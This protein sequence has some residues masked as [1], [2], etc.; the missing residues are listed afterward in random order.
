M[1][2][3]VNTDVSALP[4]THWIAVYV[5]QRKGEVFDSYGRPPPFRLQKWLNN[6]GVRW[7]FNKR[8]VQGP[9]STLCGA[10]CIF[11]LGKR[12][13]TPMNVPLH[14]IVSEEFGERFSQ[15]DVRMRRFMLMAFDVRM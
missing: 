1:C 13:V 3:I 5:N 9:L 12:C 6:S 7:T 15:N 11:F 8:L 10:Y 2:L 4:G 14:R